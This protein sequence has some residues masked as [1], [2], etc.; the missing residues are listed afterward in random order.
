[1]CHGEPSTS[2][3]DA[4]LHGMQPRES[5][6]FVGD[7]TRGTVLSQCAELVEVGGKQ[8]AAANV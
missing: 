5:H 1:M 7:I 8:R 2:V 6:P 4:H 3:M